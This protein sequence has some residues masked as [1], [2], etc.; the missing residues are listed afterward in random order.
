MMH[1]LYVLLACFASSGVLLAGL[2]FAFHAPSSEPRRI[3]EEKERKLKGSAFAGRLMFNAAFSSALVFG[4]TLGLYPYL[5]EDS[6][7]SLWRVLGQFFGVMILY[8]FL[9]Y[10][11]HRFLFHE[12]KWLQ[13]VHA[14]HHTAKYPTAIDSLYLHPVETFLGLATL[15]ITLRVFGP[16]NVWSFGV[17]F[18]VYSHLN[19]LLHCGLVLPGG[20]LLAPLNY[21]HKKHDRHH[22]SMKRGNF[23]SITPVFDLLFGTAE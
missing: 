1:L 21:M 17:I 10:L 22:V 23:A 20:A 19:I 18:F 12:W 8:D 14:V 9:Y 6:I 11:L 2:H 5:F 3:R 7:P 16:I 13:S 4:S 15:L